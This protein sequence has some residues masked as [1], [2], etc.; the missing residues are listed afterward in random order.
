MRLVFLAGRYWPALGGV[1]LLVHH[2]AN[3]LAERHEVTV[4]AHR[5]DDSPTDRLSD[6]LHHPPPFAPFNDGTVRVV[7]VDMPSSAR[8]RLL[9]LGLQVV[10]IAGRYAFGRMRVALAGW[11]SQV[12]SRVLAQHVRGADLLH[13]WATDLIAANGVGAA[14]RAGV[15]VVITPFVHPGQWGYDPGSVR[16][17]RR[18]DRVLGLLNVERELFAGLG[19]PQERIAVCG[20]CTPGVRTGGGAALRER[21]GLS[22]PLVLFLGARR[23]YKGHDLLLAAAAELKSSLP[24]AVFAFVGP[25][26]PLPIEQLGPNVVDGGVVDD[27]ERGTWLEAADLLCL[28][29]AHEIFPLSLL[30]AFSARTPALVSDLPPLRELMV[31]SGG[32]RVVARTVPAIA[33]MLREMLGD[34]AALRRMG[35]A[36]HAFWAE[37][38]TPDAVARCHERIYESIV[39]D[40]EA[41]PDAL[42]ISSRMT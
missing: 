6:S 27:Q 7:P 4:I 3:A 37:G 12:M 36:G 33:A 28:P 17:Y 32:G 41:C 21:L 25:G 31:R 39:D 29:S 22:G 11:S 18:A 19:V 8:F 16:T 40:R 23:P 14:R 30:E 38:F 35:E 34:P 26:D 20:S 10:P 13:I 24:D 2:V 9:P 5:I 15:P 42:Q 1:E